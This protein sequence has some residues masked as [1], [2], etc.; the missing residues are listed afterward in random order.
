MSKSTSDRYFLND[1]QMEID[2]TSEK[3]PVKLKYHAGGRWVDSKTDKYMPCYNTST[4]AVIAYAPRCRSGEVEEAIRAAVKA[5][6]KWAN[7]AVGKRVQV[8]TRM[9]ATKFLT[10]RSERGGPWKRRR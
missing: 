1:E 7:T 2:P 3:K 5:Y 8:L 4:G 9:K 10:S 6:P